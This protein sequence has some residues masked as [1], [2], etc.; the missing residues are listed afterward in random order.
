[1]CGEDGPPTRVDAQHG[2]P[3]LVDPAVGPFAVEGL[4]DPLERAVSLHAEPR[5]RGPQYLERRGGSVPVSGYRQAVLPGQLATVAFVAD[6][7]IPGP[8]AVAA[9]E[10]GAG[11]DPVVG[12]V[13]NIATVAAV[14]EEAVVATVGEADARQLILRAP[15]QPVAPHAG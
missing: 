11:E 4:G 3:R 7:L 12:A 8:E 2:S 1:P 15:D 10:A 13:D 9:I 6:D 5:R 14:F